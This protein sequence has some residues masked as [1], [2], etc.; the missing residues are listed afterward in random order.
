MGWNKHAARRK[1]VKVNE[2]THSRAAFL[3]SR[4]GK[5]NTG[6]DD[7]DHGWRVPKVLPERVDEW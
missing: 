1:E 3:K 7:S 4:S 5:G 6:N 2:N